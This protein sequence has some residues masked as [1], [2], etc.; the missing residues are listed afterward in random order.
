MA[1]P[2][3][4]RRK[5]TCGNGFERTSALKDAGV[6]F[7]TLVCCAAEMRLVQ[8]ASS[9]F[10]L[11]GCPSRTWDRAGWQLRHVRRDL[12]GLGQPDLVAMT[13]DML[14]GTPELPQAEWLAQE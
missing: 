10:L 8:L 7:T 2:A 6:D 14:H 4:S 13:Q 12:A 3:S 9:R 1:R 5:K 11:P